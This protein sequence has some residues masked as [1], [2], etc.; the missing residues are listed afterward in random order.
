MP[1][2]NNVLGH[3]KLLRNLPSQYHLVTIQLSQIWT[4][5]N[6]IRLLGVIV[7]L[8]QNVILKFYFQSWCSLKFA[9]KKFYEIRSWR[10][11]ARVAPVIK[12]QTGIQWRIFMA[13]YKSMP[14]F[15]WLLINEK[16]TFCHFKTTRVCARHNFLTFP[17]F[18]LLSA[19][20]WKKARG[21]KT[22]F[23]LVSGFSQAFSFILYNSILSVSVFKW[24][25]IVFPSVCECAHMCVCMGVC[26][27]VCELVS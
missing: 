1:V 11:Q 10:N 26:V 2:F 7:T 8:L 4:V 6:L 23:P 13:W 24:E 21:D 3:T 17:P 27:C 20:T 19:E 16:L 15:S 14:L 9:P 25:S 5:V 12:L 18:F 22:L